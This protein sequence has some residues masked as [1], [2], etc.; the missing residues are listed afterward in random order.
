MG[1]IMHVYNGA[2][3][4]EGIEVDPVAVGKLA[5]T[6]CDEGFWHRDLPEEPESRDLACRIFESRREDVGYCAECENL[7]GFI[8]SK[9]NIT[10]RD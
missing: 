6:L 5:R 7:A 1:G 10:E 8:V 3:V 9:F 2:A 4:V